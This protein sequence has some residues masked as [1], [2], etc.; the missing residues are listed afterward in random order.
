LK[1]GLPVCTWRHLLAFRRQPESVCGFIRQNSNIT[2]YL[3]DEVLT[4]QLPA[5]QTFY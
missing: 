4:H 2:G 1:A 3:V 5:I